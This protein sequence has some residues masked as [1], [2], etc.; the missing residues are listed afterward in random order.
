MGKSNGPMITEEAAFILI[1]EYAASRRIQI[2][3]AKG[4]Q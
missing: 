1:N 4:A 2:R 3:I